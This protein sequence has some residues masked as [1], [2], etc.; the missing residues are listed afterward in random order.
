MVL[1]IC[2]AKDTV[3]YERL[4]GNQ[5]LQDV[6]LTHLEEFANIGWYCHRHS[7]CCSL[8]VEWQKWQSLTYSW[9]WMLWQCC[10]S[11]LWCVYSSSKYDYIKPLLTQ[12]HWLKIP[13]RIEFKL[14]KDLHRTAPLYLADEFHQS[15]DVEACCRLHCASS[16]LLVIWCTSLSTIGDRAFP[17][18]A[19]RLWTLCRRMSRRRRHWLFLGKPLKI[20]LFYRSFPQSSVVPMRLLRHLGLCSCSFYL[21]TYF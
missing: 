18:A 9:H 5:P 17:V 4:E 10:A 13:E 8:L 3:I 11:R 15:P 21:L 19:S 7:Y 12:L 14:A 6:T 20:H 1:T 16:A 2:S